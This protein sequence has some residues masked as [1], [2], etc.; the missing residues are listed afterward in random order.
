MNTS[1]FFPRSVLKINLEKT[2]SDLNEV[3]PTLCLAKWLHSSIN[4]Q[5]GLTHSCY[6]NPAHKISIK[7]LA[8]NPNALFQTEEKAEQR[9]EMLTG[10]RPQ[11]CSFC[12]NIEN[13]KNSKI[14]SDRIIK[15]TASWARPYF[16]EMKAGNFSNEILPTYIEVSFSNQCNL[17]CLY[18]GPHNS[19]SW[20]LDL[21]QNGPYST[22]RHF[23]H[24]LTADEENEITLSF[25]KI[26]PRLIERLEIIRITGGE[27]LLAYQFWKILES[28]DCKQKR[29]QLIINSNLS[30]SISL[31]KKLADKITHL[32]NCGGNSIKIISS[33]EATNEQ[34]EYVRSG[35]S[36]NLFLEN[37][38]LLSK[39][40][41][42]LEFSITSTVNA[43][44][45]DGYFNFL[46]FF[47]RFRK[48][49]KLNLVLDPSPLKKPDFLNI[50]YYP[51]KLAELFKNKIDNFLLSNRSQISD[52]EEIKLIAL[53]EIAGSE[54]RQ[55]STMGR[56]LFAFCEE[57]DRRNGTSFQ[58]IF[59]LL[60]EH[61]QIYG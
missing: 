21:K 50:A 23:E 11:G 7:E 59:P 1:I 4:L 13:Q 48:E 22:I 37:I 24:S 26:W 41:K 34:A 43:F 16:E 12:W 53:R 56:K 54:S 33:L 36:F 10:N 45:I 46:E 44:S 18:C 2:F 52:Y 14:F 19:S 6:H 60:A 28:F 25:W 5:G 49:Q 51:E 8:H 15:S 29:P 57:H 58:K 47:I 31:I 38:I 42:P 55:S 20:A 32:Q 61:R 9:K 30:V 3:S 40:P 35:L 39:V 17:R 27:P